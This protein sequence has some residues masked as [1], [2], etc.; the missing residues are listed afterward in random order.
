MLTPNLSAEIGGGGIAIDPGRITYAANGA[1]IMNFVNTRATIGYARSVFPN[2][3]GVP[4]QVVANVVSLSAVQQIGPQWQ[5]TGGA[6]YSQGSRTTEAA[7]SIKFNS[8]GGSVDLVY[9]VTRI[10]TTALGY[11]YQRFDQDFGTTKNQ[12]D[13]HVVMF[14]L[15]ASWE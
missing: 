14:S 11:S 12:F 7:N 3:L 10:W 8:Y 2:F 9:M 1:L 5:V 4:T 6:N 13:R 15:R